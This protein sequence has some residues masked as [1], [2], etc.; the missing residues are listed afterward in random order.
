MTDWRSH[1]QKCMKNRARVNVLKKITNNHVATKLISIFDVR[2]YQLTLI[3]KVNHIEN[4]RY[5]S[6]SSPILTV[7]SMHLTSL[8]APIQPKN[9]R[10]Q[11]MPDVM[12]R[13]HTAPV[14][15]FVPKSSLAKF[16]SMSVQRPKPK[17][18]A[19]PNWKLRD[20]TL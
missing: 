16:W 2:S 3:L 18:M 12:T 6:H 15:K 8:A 17:T 14:N 5:L 9:E 4:Y 19:P 7:R 13:T 20:K 10:M 11:V 1:G